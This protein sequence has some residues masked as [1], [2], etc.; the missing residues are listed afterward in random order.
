MSW[1]ETSGTEA[2]LPIAL[3]LGL[4][5]IASGAVAQAQQQPRSVEV[6]GRAQAAAARLQAELDCLRPK[7]E[8]L[9]RILRALR[10]PIARSSRRATWARAPRSSSLAPIL[11]RSKSRRTGRRS[12]R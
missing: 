3:S 6:T 5:L 2:R 12:A 7:R 10:V 4:V 9:D 1:N 11:T 8:E